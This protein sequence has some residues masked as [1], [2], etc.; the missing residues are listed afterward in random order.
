[1]GLDRVVWYGMVWIVAIYLHIFACIFPYFVP[2]ADRENK[3]K[4]KKKKQR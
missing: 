2:D 3:K 1:M 4:K